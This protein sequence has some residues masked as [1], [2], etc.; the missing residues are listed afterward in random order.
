MSDFFS[1]FWGYY[2]AT[3]TIGGLAFCVFLLTAMSTRKKK[4]SEKPELHGHV[5]DGDLQEYNNPLPRWWMG[6]FYIT[7]AFGIGY[8]ILYPGLGHFAGTL[9]WSSKG[10][11]TNEQLKAKNEL[12]PLFNKYDQ[13]DLLAVAADPEAR[14][15]GQ[16]LF[17]TN[18][19]QCHGSDA[20]G[21][22]GFP[23][24][25][26]K[27]WLYGG[28]LE[29]IQASITEGR[30]GTMPPF[31]KIYGNAD[32]EDVAYYV[33]SLSGYPSNGL[34]KYSGRKIFMNSCAS[35]HG[36]EGKG[37]QFVGAPNLTDETWLHGESPKDVIETISKGR[38]SH[39]PS[40]KDILDLSKIRLITAYVYGLSNEP[41]KLSEQANK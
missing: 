6:M 11:Y 4:V 39:M 15:T 22:K 40:H 26:D 5:W 9:G 13:Q 10:E 1:S 38:S 12:A 23:N 41:D 14:A 16:R 33:L 17:L 29:S 18:C 36:A 32:I 35:C 8:L 31:G 3:L 24:L 34:Q 30:N 7:I 19:S 2:I 20:G 27:D 25:T 21:S 37:N 28:K